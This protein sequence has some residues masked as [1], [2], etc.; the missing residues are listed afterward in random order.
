MDLFAVRLPALFLLVV[1]IAALA[2]AA[3]ALTG[4]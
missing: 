1:A 2:L 3:P 4:L